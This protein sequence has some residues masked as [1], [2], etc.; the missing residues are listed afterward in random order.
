MSVLNKN[1]I[2]DKTFIRKL[3]YL[4]LLTAKVFKGTLQ[5]KRKSRAQGA[6]PEFMDYR[7]YTRGDEIKSIDWYLYA[8]L[9]TLMLKLY[10]EEEDLNIYF[11]LDASRSMSFGQKEIFAKKVTAALAYVSL[12]NFDRV[13]VLA[14]SSEHSSVFPLTRGKGKFFSLLQ[15]L[16]SQKFSGKTQLTATAHQLR[17]L[18]KKPGVVI[19]L[20]DFFDMDHYQAAVKSVLFNKHDVICFQV[21]NEEEVKPPVLGETILSD[22]ETGERMKVTVRR[23]DLIRYEKRMAAYMNEMQ[24]FFTR[25][26]VRFLSSPDSVDFVDVVLKLFRSGGFLK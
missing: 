3:E 7:R 9:E 11:V 8:R 20:S 1:T 14:H 2:F 12:R 26:E 16:E 25:M 6:S 19:I 22:A 24:T 13:A 10:E 18:A 4:Y 15:F 5:A 17:S 21:L 23:P